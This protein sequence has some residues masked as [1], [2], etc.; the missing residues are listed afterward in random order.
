MNSFIVTYWLAGVIWIAALSALVYFVGWWALPALIV[1]A[2]AAWRD[3][4]RRAFRAV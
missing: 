2:I 1:A 3:T 4:I